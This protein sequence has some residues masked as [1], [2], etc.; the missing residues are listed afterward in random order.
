M[1][2]SAQAQGGSPWR[3]PAAVWVT[4][5]VALALLAWVFRG[6]L[7]FLVKNWEQPEYGYAYLIPFITAFL[8]WQR[9]DRLEA[10]RFTGSAWGAI[11]VALGLLVAFAGRLGAVHTV[12][13]YGVFIAVLGL[14]WAFYGGKAF[15]TVAVPLLLLG[16]AIPLPDFLY[17]SLSNYLQWVSSRLG[18]DV[19]RLFSVPVYLEGNVIDLGVYKL[20][21]AEACSGLRYLFPLVTLSFVAAYLYQVTFWKRAVV[22][23]SALPITVFMNSFRIGMIGILVGYWGIS[24]A[25]GFLH[26]FEGWAIFMACILLLVAEMWILA[27]IGRDR[28]PLREAFAL[29]FPAAAPAGTS[30]RARPIPRAFWVGCALI[31]VAGISTVLIPS[32][33]N[34][35]PKRLSFAEFPLRLGPW[36]GAP[37]ALGEIYLRALN[38]DDYIMANYRERGSDAPV[39]LYIGYYDRQG[40]NKVPHSPKACLPAGGWLM[41]SIGLH[42]VKGVRVSGV[43]LR[44]NRVVI[45]QGGATQLVYYW[46]QERGRVITN[47]YSAKYYIFLDSIT[48]HRTD[49]ALVRL[50]T[51]VGPNGSLEN[52]DRRL[53]SFARYL[54]P[55]L[56]RYV[57]D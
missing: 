25:E 19:I 13:Q 31:L 6:S 21:V 8:I 12:I 40:A 55:I 33:K 52:A 2:R 51:M 34:V 22:F 35:T 42:D 20:Q 18:V 15:R 3:T 57:P 7:I 43:P 45:S 37:D 44:V 32:I 46:F 39:N 23:L 9:K 49:G 36:A 50:I 5:S 38:L 53:T 56:P 24:Q 1:V 54:A 30:A 11:V 48:R 10:I 41:T 17:H 14:F 4:F 27:K 28:R 47:E 16:F 29:D 26:W